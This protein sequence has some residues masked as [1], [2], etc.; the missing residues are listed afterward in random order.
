[1]TGQF[2]DFSVDG[3]G[4]TGIDDQGCDWAIEAAPGWFTGGA[5]RGSVQARM[6]QAGDWRGR[7]YRAGRVITLRGDIKAPSTVALEEASRRLSSVLS[8]GGF[9]TLTGSSPAGIL[10]STVQLDDSPLFDPLSDVYATWQI[11]VGSEDP[12]L[13][14]PVTFAETT[15][16]AAAAGVGRVWA[17]VWPRDWGVPA[18]VTPGAVSLSNAG[19]SSYLPRLRVD[20]PVTNPVVTLAE[21]GDSLRYAGLVAAGQWLDIDC[22]RRRVLLNGQVSQRH[23][24]SF[25]GAWLAVPVGGGTVTW[26][27]DSY[28]TGHGLSVWGFEGAWA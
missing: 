2:H 28:G 21:T 13:Y 7:Q 15:L 18:G 14:G 9:G 25:V 10:S 17:R 4:L 3:F 6:Q 12:L 27:A 19:T 24:V 1:M 5:V 22:G 26:T 23:R 8:S 16:A 11:T 20:G